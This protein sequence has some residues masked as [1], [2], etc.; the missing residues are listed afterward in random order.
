MKFPVWCGDQFITPF[1]CLELYM[2]NKLAAQYRNF[3][4]CSRI[5]VLSRGI[6]GKVDIFAVIFMGVDCTTSGV[7]AL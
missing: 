1:D 5:L 2:L 6:T 7:T 3:Q 4:G